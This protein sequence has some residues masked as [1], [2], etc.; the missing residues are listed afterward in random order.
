MAQ[1]SPYL[2]KL[3]VLHLRCSRYRA[4]TVLRSFRDPSFVSCRVFQMFRTRLFVPR[5]FFPPHIDPAVA[6]CTTLSNTKSLPAERSLFYSPSFFYSPPRR[7][8]LPAAAS[9]GEFLLRRSL[10][11]PFPLAEPLPTCL[12]SGQ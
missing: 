1:T 10:S 3:A 11:L 7:M 6:L 5:P 12:F 2:T 8:C 9:R 4:G